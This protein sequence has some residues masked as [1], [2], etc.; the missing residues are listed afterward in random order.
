[1]SKYEANVTLETRGKDGKFDLVA[2]VLEPG[3]IYLL[4]VP[5][6]IPELLDAYDH[7]DDHVVTSVGKMIAREKKIP[8]IAFTKIESDIKI[9][10]GKH[11]VEAAAR[12]RIDRIKGIY[13]PRSAFESEQVQQ[14]F[15]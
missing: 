7:L 14:I 15:L 2:G 5:L 6:F 1:M 11:V 12:L 10:S 4:D 8:L 9:V 13:V 3:M